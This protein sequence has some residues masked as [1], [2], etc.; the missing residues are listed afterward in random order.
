MLKKE[1]KEK[2]AAL[3]K[4]AVLLKIFCAS[5]S[6]CYIDC[7]NRFA[8]QG[9]VGMADINGLL[10]MDTSVDARFTTFQCGIL[11]GRIGSRCESPKI[12]G[13][14]GKTILA[15][16]YRTQYFHNGRGDESMSSRKFWMWRSAD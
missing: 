12:I 2:K 8:D 11:K 16:K 6:F 10:I 4:E 15:A 1:P 9:T 13:V 3:E 5:R 14:V 7:G